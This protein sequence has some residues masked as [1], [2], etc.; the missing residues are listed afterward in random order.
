VDNGEWKGPYGDKCTAYRVGGDRNFWSVSVLQGNVAREEHRGACAGVRLHGN[1]CV[2]VVCVCVRVNGCAGVGLLTEIGVHRCEWD[3]A[4]APNACPFSCDSCT[5][6]MK[7]KF[8][9]A[10][11]LARKPT[12]QGEAAPHDGA[13]PSSPTKH[14][15]RVG[16]AA[17]GAVVPA[18]PTVGSMVGV[19]R[20]GTAQMLAQDTAAA[21][22]S[23]SALVQEV[24]QLKQRLTAIAKATGYNMKHPASGQGKAGLSG[25][26]AASDMH[27]FY[28]N[29]GANDGTSDGKTRVIGTARD[30]RHQL[31]EFFDSLP[32]GLKGR[33]REG[34]AQQ[35]PKGGNKL[36]AYDKEYVEDVEKTYGQQAAQHVVQAEKA[37]R[38][39]YQT[40]RRGQGIL[41]VGGVCLSLCMASRFL[42]T[43]WLRSWFV[44]ERERA[45]VCAHGC[46]WFVCVCV[47]VCVHGC[48]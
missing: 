39:A 24:A 45:F 25:K 43:R 13:A 2:C 14:E 1:A 9:A 37:G 19:Q 36:N 15:A 3:G 38:L 26:A 18:V 35:L 5:L 20:K 10:Q 42:I 33:G 7:A 6:K 22:V 23:R 12:E 40:R 41:H 31:G 28:S 27:D 47:C 44:R 48:L 8:L 30:A 32:T 34:G 21:K 16:V 29:M 46:S 17:S 11:A 4:D